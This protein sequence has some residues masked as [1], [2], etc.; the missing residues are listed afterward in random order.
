MMMLK[1]TLIEAQTA[2][3]FD[4]T[5]CMVTEAVAIVENEKVVGVRAVLRLAR[6]LTVVRDGALV[7]TGHAAELDSTVPILQMVLA[8]PVVQPS[9]PKEPVKP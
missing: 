2:R 5:P 3:M 6:P 7:I 4:E 8:Q 9:K 1:A